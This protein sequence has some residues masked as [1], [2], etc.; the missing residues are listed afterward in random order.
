MLMGTRLVAAYLQLQVL[1]VY[2]GF[3]AKLIEPVIQVKAGMTK[4]DFVQI[5][6]S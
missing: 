3:A 5:D 1:W 4:D 2:I 6:V